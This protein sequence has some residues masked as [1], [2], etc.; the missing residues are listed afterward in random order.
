MHPNKL[1]WNINRMAFSL[2]LCALAIRLVFVFWGADFFYPGSKFIN[3]DS[4]SYSQSFINLVETGHYT[5][6]PRIP[7]ASFGRLPGYPFFWGMHYLVFGPE[8]VYTT[9]AITQSILDSLSALMVFLLTLHLTKSRKGALGAGLLYALYPFSIV[10]VTITGTETLGTFLALLLALIIVTQ[11]HNKMN[12]ILAGL[13]LGLAFFT[14]E[15]LGILLPIT[16]LYLFW[17]HGFKKGWR[18]AF[19]LGM[20]FLVVYL[21]W[22]IRNYAYHQRLVF[23]KPPTAG[24]IRYTADVNSFRS[25]VFSWQ[26]SDWQPYFDEMVYG[27]EPVNFPDWIFPSPEERELAA[28]LVSLSR[29][30]G[31]GFHAWKTNQILEQNCN[32]EIATGF[33]EL[34][35]SFIRHKP[36]HYLV[37]SPAKSVF[38]CF[39]KT[40]AQ[41][42]QSKTKATLFFVLFLGRGLLLIILAYYAINLAIKKKKAVFLISFPIFMVLFL[43]FFLRQVEMRYLL[44]AEALMIPFFGMLICRLFTRKEMV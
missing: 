10:W 13:V 21:P 28:N 11:E 43:S 39:F 31:S 25:W 3:N 27:N 15:Y 17:V 33:Q 37:V 19:L 30:C 7:D 24:Y 1:F 9:V 6:D 36:F 29:E 41:P 2:F 38:K 18:K 8:K 16:V 22:P 14:R 20:V 32:P 5:H 34:R 35:K 12:L 44:Q 4:G 23:I 26:P 42:G 40:D